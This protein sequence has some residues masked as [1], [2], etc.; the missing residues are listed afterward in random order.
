MVPV[1]AATP[2]LPRSAFYKLA[3]SL[4]TGIMAAGAKVDTKE[5]KKLNHD[6][7]KERM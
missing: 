7:W 2:A 1:T 3:A 4:I 6:K 5:V